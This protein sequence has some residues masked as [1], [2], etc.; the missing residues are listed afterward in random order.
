M[1]YPKID[2]DGAVVAITG[3]ARGIG[4]ATA[5][6]FAT[7]GATVCIGDLDADAAAES[8]AVIGGTGYGLD[9]TSK[10]SFAEFIGAVLARH[11]RI[12]ILVNNAGIMPLG[13]FIAENDATSRATLDVNVWGPIQGMRLALPHMIDRG[14]G[15]IVNVASMAG[16]LV[17]PGMAVYNAS[18]FA[19]VGLSAAVREEY[20]D[21]GVSVSAI[22]PSAVRTRLSSGVPLGH[23]MPTVDPEDVARAIVDSVRNRSAEITVPGYLAGWDLVNAAVPERLMRLG[24]KLIGDRRALTSIDHSVRGA[25]ERAIEAQARKADK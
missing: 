21:T 3:G 15:H 12:D 10:E 24:R 5:E 8:A 4:K 11:G 2:I 20:R 25:Y 19:A 6:L 16:K 17:V 14:S 7:K 9:V 13:D 18:K 23:G 22:L 1:A